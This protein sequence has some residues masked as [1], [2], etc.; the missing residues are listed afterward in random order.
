MALWPPCSAGHAHALRH[1]PDRRL[2]LF[3]F[4]VE[5]AVCSGSS[6]CSS[7]VPLLGRR[8]LLLPGLMDV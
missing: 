1:T 5:L 3:A 7:H 4:G 8:A 6:L 2:R